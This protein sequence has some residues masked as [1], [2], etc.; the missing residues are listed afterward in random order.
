M[1][2][3][4]HPADQHHPAPLDA[5]PAANPA[6]RADETVALRIP[7]GEV[8]DFHSQEPVLDVELDAQ[9]S[10]GDERRETFRPSPTQVQQARAWL[11]RVVARRAVEILKAQETAP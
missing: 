4:S 5:A 11:V 10:Y 6:G 3:N 1:T 7:C 9:R 2:G 8:V